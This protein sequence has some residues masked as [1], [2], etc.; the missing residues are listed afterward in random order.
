MKEIDE[1]P[2]VSKRYVCNQERISRSFILDFMDL[3]ILVNM[4]LL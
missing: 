3:L 1:E 4:R 2:G